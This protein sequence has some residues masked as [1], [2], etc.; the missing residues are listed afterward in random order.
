MRISDRGY[1]EEGRERLTL[2]PENVDDL[3]HPRT[4]SNPGTSSRATPP[5]G[6]SETTTR[7]GTPA[8]SANTSS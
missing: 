6:S 7:C 3:W 8:A 4:S 1:G 5:A 2:V